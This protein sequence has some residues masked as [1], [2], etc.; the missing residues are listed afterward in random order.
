[1]LDVGRLTFADTNK[2]R[3]DKFVIMVYNINIIVL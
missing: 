1:M 3:I 2:C